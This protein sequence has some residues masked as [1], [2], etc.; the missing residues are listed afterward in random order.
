MKNLLLTLL[1]ITNSLALFAQ[2]DL[3]GI[4]K[5]EFGGQIKLRPNHTFEYTWGF[6]LS[7][8]WN[9]GTWKVENEKYLILE[10]VEIRDS[11]RNGN[12]IKFVLSSDTISNEISSYENAINSLPSSGQSR[13]LPPKKLKISNS[14][15]FPYTKNNKIQ[16]KKLKSILSNQYRKPWFVKQ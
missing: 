6:D 11:I 9:N 12:E 13:S 14:K 8:S 15:L 5:D 7:S 10:V 16:N 2:A 4:Y 3:S 1:L